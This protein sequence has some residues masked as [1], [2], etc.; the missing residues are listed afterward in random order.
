MEDGRGLTLEFDHVVALKEGGERLNLRNIAPLC[1]AH[2]VA[3]TRR[4]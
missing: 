4:S 3:K 1:H 2:Y